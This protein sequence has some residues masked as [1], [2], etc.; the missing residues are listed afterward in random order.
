[1]TT[2]WIVLGVVLMTAL[3]LKSIYAAFCTGILVAQLAEDHISD[4]EKSI[5]KQTIESEPEQT[6]KT[7]ET[8]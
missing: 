3:W 1:M 7:E 5:Y 8:L 6:D 2:F 4:W